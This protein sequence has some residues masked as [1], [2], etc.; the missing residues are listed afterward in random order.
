[1]GTTLTGR[2]SGLRVMNSTE[3][4]RSPS[5]QLRGMTPILVIDGVAYENMSLRDVPVDNIENVTVLKGATATALYGSM[6]AGGAI[7]IST[8]KGLAQKGVD[9]S[10]NSNN[11]FSPAIWLYQKY[12]LPI[13]PATAEGTIRMM[14]CGETNWILV[15]FIRNGIH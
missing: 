2:I 4:N 6:G 1:V 8:K 3:F 14:K 15:K 11:M 5:I 9:I 13:L 7:M 12:N 10:V